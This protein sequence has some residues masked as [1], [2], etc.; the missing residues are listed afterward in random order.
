MGDG[1]DSNYCLFADAAAFC[2]SGRSNLRTSPSCEWRAVRPASCRGSPNHVSCLAPITAAELT[3]KCK[4][5]VADPLCRAHAAGRTVV[6]PE[7]MVVGAG[8]V[9]SGTSTQPSNAF[10]RNG[11]P[12]FT[13][14]SRN[15]RTLR[16]LQADGTLRDDDRY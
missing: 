1:K 14:F 13:N 4:N 8:R 16:G 12:V 2:A 6:K 5:Y 9:P 15:S 11:G 3:Q 10:G 7:S